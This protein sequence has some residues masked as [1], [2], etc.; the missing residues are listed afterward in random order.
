[1]PPNRLLEFDRAQG[2]AQSAL[3]GREASRV[4]CPALI[5]PVVNIPLLLLAQGTRSGGDRARPPRHIIEI[6]PGDLMI[7][8]AFALTLAQSTPPPAPAPPSNSSSRIEKLPTPEE[9]VSL[10]S[11]LS[12]ESDRVTADEQSAAWTMH[13]FAECLVRTRERQMVEFLST[14]LN[15]P[16][17]N[18][19]V[20]EVIGWRS[21]C[22]H[23]R[24][25]QIDH[26]LLRGA[27]A[28][29]TATTTD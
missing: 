20:R 7:L 28:P 13:R 27:I 26:T 3:C 1:M 10:G 14:R 18:R 8:A 22:L 15:S 23:A 12:R 19:I 29:R 17:E 9:E 4:R 6:V 5:V 24:S 25:M 21:R 16:E 2:S 11:R